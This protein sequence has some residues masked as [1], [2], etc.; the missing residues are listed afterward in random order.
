MDSLPSIWATVNFLVAPRQAAGFGSLF[1]GAPAKEEGANLT[2]AKC[3]FLNN[4]NG[5]VG[6]RRIF[7]EV[8]GDDRALGLGQISFSTS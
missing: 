2:V 1:A 6:V 3:P 8:S 5:I 7:R 4:S